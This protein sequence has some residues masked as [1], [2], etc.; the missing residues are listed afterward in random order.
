MKLTQE[1]SVEI[2]CFFARKKK[3]GA[4]FP[5][6]PP[7]MPRF[8]CLSWSAPGPVFLE[9]QNPGVLASSHVSLALTSG[10]S[11]DIYFSE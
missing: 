2:F 11:K 7:K 6:G 4:D 8:P 9:W 5:A 10:C 3:S 1:Q